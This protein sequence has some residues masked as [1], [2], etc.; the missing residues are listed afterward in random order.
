MMPMVA[1]LSTHNGKPSLLKSLYV[2]IVC[3]QCAWCQDFTL[4]A[5]RWVKDG[6]IN[7]FSDAERLRYMHYDSCGLIAIY[8]RLGGKHKNAGGYVVQEIVH[9]RMPE[10]EH[11]VQKFCEMDNIMARAQEVFPQRFLQKWRHSN[12]HCY[13][14]PVLFTALKA[15]RRPGD[16]TP[17]PR[18]KDLFD[19]AYLQG[20][21]PASIFVHGGVLL[22]VAAAV[23]HVRYNEQQP[24]T[25][26]R[27]CHALERLLPYVAGVTEYEHLAQE[28][29]ATGKADMV[30][31][32]DDVAHRGQALGP[33][34]VSVYYYVM[35]GDHP[36]GK[37]LG[38]WFLQR[39][40]RKK[41]TYLNND[42]SFVVPNDVWKNAYTF[43]LKHLM[44]A[45]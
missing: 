16:K 43:V 24:V 32:E 45:P 31:L 6:Y 21:R 18:L 27:V 42:W 8:M 15:Q 7:G 40:T 14:I 5:P 12:G 1:L 25:L 36:V 29:L 38:S 9:K 26:Q 22:L 35:H 2:A 41:Q 13:R 19:P 17:I 34:V 37:A 44:L 3:A 20:L 4:W 33:C 11:N 28:A 10:G 23:H 39:F 30:L